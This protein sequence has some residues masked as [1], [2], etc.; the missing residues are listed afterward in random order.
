M[1]VDDNVKSAFEYAVLAGVL[2]DGSGSAGI[3]KTGAGML[4]LSRTNTYT[5][6][7]T[8]S[9]GILKA[10]VGVGIPKNSRLILDGG[11]LQLNAATIFGGMVEMTANG[12]GFTAGSASTTVN[13]G[14]HATPDLLVW[15]SSAGSQLAGTLRLNSPAASAALTFQNG[16]DLN[17]DARTLTVAA[18]SVYLTGAIQDAVGGGSFTKTGTGTLYITGSPGNTYAGS[19]T[20]LGGDVYLNKTAGYAIPGDL[21]LGGSNQLFVNVQA[22]NQIASTASLHWCGT[23]A[24]QEI[25]LLGHNQTVAGI[26]DSTGRGVIENTWDEAGYAKTTLTVNNTVDCSFNGCLRDQVYNSGSVLALTKSGTGTLALSGDNISYTGGTKVEG[27]TLALQDITN[28]AFLAGSISIAADSVLEFRAAN[29][30]MDFTGT[31]T[32]AGSLNKTG[33][34][35]MTLGANARYTGGTTVTNGVL[36]LNDVSDP[37]FLA[38]PFAIENYSSLEIN[39]A[40]T[41]INLTGPISG[42]GSF[43]LEGTKTVTISGATGNTFTGTTSLYGGDVNLNKTSG[44]AI[45]GDLSFQGSTDC[46]VSLLGDNQ[47][48]PSATIYWQGYGGTQELKLLG[49]NLTVAGISCWDSGVIE[50]TKDETGSYGTAVLTVNTVSGSSSFSGTL[51]DSSTG[52]GALAL[53]K[54]GA[55][56]LTLS[57]VN[58]YTG[59]TTIK[60]GGPL[61]A[62]DGV[63]LPSTSLLVLDG[64]ILQGNTGA[65]FKRGIGVSAGDVQWTSNGGGFSASIYYPL[66]VNI[67]GNSTPSTLDWGDSVGTQIVGTLR[68]HSSS[69]RSVTTFVNPVNL[70]GVARTI[71]VDGYVNTDHYSYYQPYTYAVMS[72]VIADGS[73]AAGIVKTGSGMLALTGANTYSGATTISSG[74]LQ[75]DDSVGLPSGSFLSLD[76]GVLQSNTATTFSRPLGVSG[77]AFQWTANGGGFSA[78]ANPLTVNIGG[79]AT[80]DTLDWGNSVGSQIVGTLKLSS[81]LAKKV[82]TFVNPV[83]LNGANRTIHVAYKYDFNDYY[84]ATS[85]SEYAVMSGVIADG[86]G[87]PGAI[88]KTGSG[89]LMLTGNN[90][91]SGG[92]NVDAGLLS[93]PASASLGA[94]GSTIRIASRATLKVGD[95]LNLTNHAQL[96]N[97]GTLT[98]SL[99]ISD[100]AKAQGSGQY[101]AVAVSSG[102]TFSPGNGIGSA[103]TASASWQSGGKYVWEINSTDGYEGWTWDYWYVSGSLS[104]D[105]GSSPFTISVASFDSSNQAGSMT[106]FDATVA[107]SWMILSTGQGISGFSADAIQLDTGLLQNDLCGGR[108]YLSQSEDASQ[109]FLNF[110]PA[111]PEPCSLA[112]LAVLG[113]ALGSRWFVEKMRQPS[114]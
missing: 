11:M 29:K 45:S 114:R 91:Y 59:N 42:S 50:N 4:V 17:G 56:R 94:P 10:D 108:L 92:T 69:S 53:V 34:Y 83:N 107:Y 41:D 24:W 61:C 65:T 79:H 2:S 15:G 1:Q 64:G 39:A 5:G 57:G 23:G 13:V 60:T 33:W 18:N 44:Y 63:G 110:A 30:S 89:M 82:T 26:F 20:I 102:G 81:A 47:I 58:T 72:G 105:A 100:G 111:V 68:L 112:F 85:Y 70:N 62:D 73:G 113:I 93:A 66:T 86:Q 12:G 74:T 46:V 104:I 106:D 28:A 21:T 27:G 90:T 16:I 7:T 8:I 78:G 84:Y 67:G 109:L 19:T 38:A 71:Q 48:A 98:G 49:H 35:A 22:D 99:S 97:S 36:T 52:S 37:S 76:G 3:T 25:K 9:G 101:G 55:A 96:T 54:D 40:T 14:G 75:A 95:T 32:G 103:T 87:G 31:L 88:T 77:N 51:R 43:M 80:P 6:P